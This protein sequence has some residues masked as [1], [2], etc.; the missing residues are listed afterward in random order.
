MSNSLFLGEFVRE[1]AAACEINYYDGDAYYDHGNVRAGDVAHLLRASGRYRRDGV[2]TI[3][4]C[5]ERH[6]I[7]SYT[8]SGAWIA[9]WSGK[10]FVNL[11]AG[12]QWASTTE[13]EAID[14]LYHRKRS[15]I[16]IVSAQLAEAQDVLAILESQF[17]K[18]PPTPRPRNYYRDY[19]YY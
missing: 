5:I 2:G 11:R 16:R 15:H 17:D 19:D 13:A 3:E 9:T 14:Q 7:L 6:R 10:K 1:P 12:K 4:L 18:K 8:P